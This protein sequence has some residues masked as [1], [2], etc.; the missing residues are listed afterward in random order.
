MYS[1]EKRR[2]QKTGSS[3]F[4]IT[5]PKDWVD[6]V[7]LKSGDYVLVEKLG[8]K[9]VITPPAAEP[10]QL[11]AVLKIYPGANKMQILRVLLATYI[12]GYSIIT[13]VFD[14]NIPD[15]A[16]LV[17]EIKSMARLKLAGIEVVEESANTITLKVLLSLHELP[18]INTIRRLHLIVSSML[19]DALNLVK[20]GD[21]SIAQMIIQRDDEADRFH[22]LLVRELA[23]ALLDVKVQHELGI[24]NATE[25]LSYRIIARNL[26]RIADHAVNIAKRIMMLGG[27]RNPEYV[28]EY[29]ARDI[30]VFE[31]SMSSLYSLNRREA[32]DVILKVREIVTEIEDVLYGKVLAAPI[33]TKEKITIALLLDSVKRI[34]RYSN[35]IAEA[36]LN[37]KASKSQELEI[38]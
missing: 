14:K 27:L 15:L 7:K 32:E 22:H 18:L 11:K 25:I 30:E 37:I 24:T 21:T 35:G 20:S 12:S 36:V 33:E 19:N 29:L 1:V 16:S 8:N 2:V 28:Q 26:E 34:A 5:L 23:V 6:S 10:Q 38:K 31:K 4:I 3:S 13:L 17:T 9:L